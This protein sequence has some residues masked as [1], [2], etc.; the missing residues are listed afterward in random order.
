MKRLV[1]ATTTVLVA[2]CASAPLKVSGP[3]PRAC[4][5]AEFGEAPGLTLPNPP[6]RK[7]G[8]KSA[9]AQMAA[10]LVV[11]KGTGDM[12]KWY[13]AGPGWKAWRLWLRSDEARTMSVHLQPFDLPPA[14][15]LWV[16]AP[17]G[18]TRQGPTGGRGPSG[19]GEFWSASARG[20]EIWLEVLVPAAGKDAVK[21]EVDR[22]FA[23]LR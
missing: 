7:A 15:E 12:G 13:D 4:G 23:G 19:N 20:P 1:L 14:A 17:D 11:G 8:D 6:R 9:P 2:A 10:P 21:L 3:A 22:A 18:T 16:C 5:L